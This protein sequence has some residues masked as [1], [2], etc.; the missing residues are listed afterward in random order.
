MQKSTPTIRRCMPGRNFV[1]FEEYTNKV[2]HRKTCCAI[3]IQ[4]SN[5]YDI[6]LSKHV[7]DMFEETHWAIGN[8][9][10]HSPKVFGNTVPKPLA[11]PL[12]LKTYEESISEW[13]SS[14]K[15]N[16]MKPLIKPGAPSPPRVSPPRFAPPK[17]WKPNIKPVA[18]S[19][20]PN[21][22]RSWNPPKNWKP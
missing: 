2:G 16:F 13:A 22:P 18:P 3:K 1:G 12:K 5:N 9:Q 19:P 7:L 21:G 4:G 10:A 20:P 8:V 6:G 11:Y 15:P 14:W 17:N